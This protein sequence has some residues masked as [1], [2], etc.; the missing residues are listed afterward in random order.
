[1]GVVATKEFREGL[2]T[3][4]RQKASILESPQQILGLFTRENVGLRRT[5]SGEYLLKIPEYA[6][7]YPP[8]SNLLVR[9]KGH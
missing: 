6:R 4:K 7:A 5:V 9:E 1:M 2:S 8:S 3:C